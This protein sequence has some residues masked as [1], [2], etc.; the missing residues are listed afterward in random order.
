VV[1]EQQRRLYSAQIRSICAPTVSYSVG[2]PGVVRGFTDRTRRC[3]DLSCCR[4]QA[5]FGAYSAKPGPRRMKK[6][7]HGASVIYRT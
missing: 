3:P 4:Y 5:N 6:Q 7:A 1:D 2:D